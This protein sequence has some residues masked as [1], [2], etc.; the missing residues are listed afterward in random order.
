MRKADLKKNHDS[1]DAALQ[2][3]RSF[4]QRIL[5]AKRVISSKTEKEDIAESVLLR[6]CAHWERFVDEHLVDCIN[7]DHSQLNEY[8][9]VTIPRHPSRNLCQAIL[10][11]GGYKDF[12]SIG[13]LKG[14]TRK[15]LPDA[16]NPFLSVAAGHAE[17]IDEVFKIRNYLAHYSA[18]ARRALDRLY[19]SSYGL[20]RFEEPG[21]FLLARDARRLWGYFTA[22][23][24]ASTDMKNCY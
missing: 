3:Y 22:L 23:E 16:S 15:I 14:F 2:R 21:R 6:L 11:S 24:S 17:R 4:T 10:F 9:G 5:N 13:E 18:A 19:K 20:S 8:L 1:F 12:R 7:V